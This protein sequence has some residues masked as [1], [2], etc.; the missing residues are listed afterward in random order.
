MV[1]N[2]GLLTFAAIKHV[3]KLGTLILDKKK[4]YSTNKCLQYYFRTIEIYESKSY[5][6]NSLNEISFEVDLY[7]RLS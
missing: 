6:L 7:S 3:P 1:Y 5:I 4:N 2:D